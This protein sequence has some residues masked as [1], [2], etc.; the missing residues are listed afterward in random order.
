MRKICEDASKEIL[1]EGN[2]RD[3]ISLRNPEKYALGSRRNSGPGKTR[4]TLGSQAEP[5]L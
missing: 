3:S 5:D 2:L 1:V 4:E